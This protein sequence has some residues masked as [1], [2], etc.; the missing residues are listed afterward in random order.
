MVSLLA[1]FA[2]EI[3]ECGDGTCALNEYNLW[4]PDFVLMDIKMGEVDGLIETRRIKAAFP[5]AR[6]IIVTNHDDDDL[7]QAAREAGACDYILKEELF[8]LPDALAR[9]C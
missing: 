2:D 3:R 1:R 8:T 7:R 6:I 9:K 4:R 5:K